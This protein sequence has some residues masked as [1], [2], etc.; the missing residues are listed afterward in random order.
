MCVCFIWR[1]EGIRMGLVAWSAQ[2]LNQGN[3]IY[4]QQE[5]FNTV[6]HVMVILSHNVISLLLSSYDFA[7]AMDYNI[8]IWFAGHLIYDPREKVVWPKGLVIHR[9]RTTDV[10]SSMFPCLCSL[11]VGILCVESNIVYQFSSNKCIRKLVNIQTVQIL[12]SRTGI[13]WTQ[14]SVRKCDI[15]W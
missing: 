1:S 13:T 8:N 14:G 4:T 5:Y 7:T 6:S 9:M 11:R 12:V 3:K 2:S 15:K 10:C